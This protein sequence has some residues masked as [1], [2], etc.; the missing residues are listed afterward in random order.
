MPH[1]G[2]AL[3]AAGGTS[4]L[5]IALITD[6]RD[7]HARELEKALAGLGARAVCVALT[8]CGFD[9]Q[10]SFGLSI[11]GFR[12]RLPSAV[13]VRSMA[14]GSFE[15][16]TLRLGILHALRENRV[17]VINDRNE[18]VGIVSMKDLADTGNQD[19]KIGKAVENISAAP[20]N[21]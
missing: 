2:E 21:N 16:V 18:I 4:L 1:S 8:A 10:S 11:A 7:W 6:R 9:T 20:P 15:A 19:G 17:P 13:L 3:A 14:G 5:S 12:D